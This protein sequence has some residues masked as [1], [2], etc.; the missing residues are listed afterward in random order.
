M[1]VRSLGASAMKH[2][3]IL[4]T[5]NASLYAIRFGLI[6][7]I[8]ASF[9]LRL[10]AAPY[11]P[12]GL[13]IEWTQPD[14]SEILLKVYGDEFHART[15]TAD[16]YTV[17]FDHESKSYHYARKTND[18]TTLESTGVIAGKANPVELVLAKHMDLNADEIR[19]R[20]SIR[21]NEWEAATRNKER[22]H[23]LKNQRNAIDGLQNGGLPGAAP[24]SSTTTG[25]KV[26]LTLLIDFDDD[27]ASIP[28]AEIIHLLNSENYSGYDNYGSVRQYFRDNSNNLLDYTN[29]VTAYIR[30][31]NSLHPKSYYNDTSQ[32]CGFQGRALIS[33]ALG[34][35]KALPNYQSEILPALDS[36]SVDAENRI[37]ALNAFYAGGNGGVWSYGLWP[38]MSSMPELELSPGGKKTY[39]YQCTNIGE[40]LS[41][42]TFCHENG[43][44]LCGFPDIYDYDYDSIGGA[45]QF[46]IMNSGGFSKRPAQFCAYLKRAGGWAE[47]L[48]ISGNVPKTL[49]LNSSAGVAG[50]N[51]FYRYAKPGSPS[52]YYLIENRQASGWDGY[53]PSSG[54]A[55]WHIDESGNNNSQ[56]MV[57]NTTHDNY[58]VTLVQA[59]NLWHFQN[60][61]N[62]GDSYDLYYQ[63]NE[64]SGYSNSV[65]GT[66]SPAATWWDGSESKLSLTEF[67]ASGSQMTVTASVELSPPVVT[68][69]LSAKGVVGIPFTYQIVASG[70]P[71]SYRA[72]MLPDGLSIDSNS[73]LLSGTPT[74]PGL[75]E[76]LI[77]ATN[78]AG[79]GAATLVM[80]VAPLPHAVTTVALDQ[81][82]GWPGSGE[83]AFGH[84]EGAG[85][86]FYGNPDPAAG[87]T[88]DHV[89]GVNLSGDY[90]TTL[91]GPYYLTAGPFDLSNHKHT[92]LRFQRWL[93]T[94]S[95]SYAEAMIDVSADGQ[96]WTRVW[97]NGPESITDHSWQHLFYDISS[98][99]DGCSTVYLRW[100]YRI[101][102]KAWPFS[103][104]NIDDIEILANPTGDSGIEVTT[105]QD[106][107][108]SSLGMGSGD[109]LR[110]AIVAAATRTEPN[111]ITFLPNLDGG[112]ILLS[113]G[114][115]T[116]SSD[117][118][119]DASS[120]PTGISVS[121]DDKSAV[122][123]IMED[124]NV[125]INRVTVRD[126]ARGITN[127]GV[128]TLKDVLLILNTLNS[129]SWEASGAAIHNL[130]T[131]VMEGST[132]ASNSNFFGHG[133]GISNEGYLSLTNCTIVN[134]SIEDGDGA[135]IYNTGNAMIRNTTVSGNTTSFTGCVAGVFSTG[136]SLV[137]ENSIIAGNHSGTGNPSN[138]SH[139]GGV[140]RG[141]N[142]TTGDPMLAEYGNYGG[143]VPTMPP[144][145]GSP[146]IDTAIAQ[147]DSPTHDQR[148]YARLSGAAMD[149]GAVELNQ[150]L[151]TTAADESDLEPGV[152]TGDSLRE[153]LAVA[154]T[155]PGADLIV[156]HPGLNG[157]TITL[158]GTSVTV[159]SQVMIDA[160]NLSHGLTVS[161]AGASRVLDV[162][163]QA[164]A[165]VSN[166]TVSGGLADF[167]GGINNLGSLY[168][169]HV[170]ISR[171]TA[172]LRGGGITAYGK[173]MIRNCLVSHNH[174]A[175]YG[176]GIMCISAT[177]SLENC[178]VTNNTSGMDGGG[179]SCTGIG[180]GHVLLDSCTVSHNSAA[181][182]GGGY[183]GKRA[184]KLHGMMT[185]RNTTF[186]HNTARISG[187]G[188]KP[189]GD[190]ELTHC[191]IAQNG[192][193]DASGVPTGEGGGIA[194][195]TTLTLA[196]SILA[197]NSAASSPDIV[198]EINVLV[199]VNFVGGD[200]KLAPLAFFGSNTA[201]M[202]PVPGSPVIDGA[203]YLS[204]LPLL[205]QRGAQRVTGRFPDI[206]AVE[207][208]P[209]STMSTIDTDTDGIDDRLEPAFHMIVGLNDGDRDSD[210]DGS[211]DAEEIANM[212]NP[213]DA[214]SRF[215]IMKLSSPTDYGEEYGILAEIKFTSFP[216][217]S[218]SLQYDEDLN[219]GSPAMRTEYL[220]IAKD[221]TQTKRVR[222]RPGKD[223]VRVLRNP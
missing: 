23:A 46:C 196:N 220:G 156:F 3:A 219:F 52:E 28:Q 143:V 211:G 133:A 141:S 199:G 1:A 31:P 163:S 92:I 200:P 47:T 83:W 73:G 104:W 146:A 12:D 26:G 78:S 84:P 216:G 57:A 150:L 93:N 118:T 32:S 67:S 142:L 79:D 77:V 89:F 22:W 8:A 192:C 74:T 99:A 63:G 159:D 120:L 136:G 181:D 145:A 182:N 127:H 129:S 11:G 170:E 194:S 185:A 222:F 126:G 35:L 155:I 154:T 217:L 209:F 50:F 62:S 55:V 223:F 210:G 81:N 153:T 204:G 95:D 41:I 166:L 21:R 201:V 66:S 54:I 132:V 144:L 147:P 61:E 190:V 80:N 113:H 7:L 20:A 36:V 17:I 105:V 30:I 25:V 102:I 189:N 75:Y 108:D 115:M 167:G 76:V 107:N 91:G 45:G 122:F 43:H 68:S 100:G 112:T 27:P 51:R 203:S 212:T 124:S 72:D 162:A 173:T 171:N 218:Y 180:T 2:L 157:A 85:G 178:T 14:G 116:V 130:G 90:S 69:F 187:G 19:R 87:A 202:P 88:G 151:V 5:M 34:I 134:N 197:G 215:Q 179:I 135:G 152:G 176:G 148:G 96:S 160:G 70:S 37:L 114:A 221:F 98:V 174:A 24:P 128:L 13:Q 195:G 4:N 206:G 168:L 6:S 40:S 191:T 106:E 16:G 48:E 198:G 103:G 183:A 15:E 109:S 71:S 38:H 161:G 64:S 10:S 29:V 165:S 125:Q 86:V 214:M 119:I 53:L 9:L 140:L 42:G 94:E 207:A 111:I 158:G 18:G 121:A 59:D 138:L 208:F 137:V 131:L 101:K 60:H 177:V 172:T 49:S 65:S 175:E 58:E 193:F 164:F 123:T 205:D 186:A 82:P 117:V 33:D 139:S 149:I 39:L 188:I 169:D 56:N 44:L 184:Y 97:N 213:N 110:E